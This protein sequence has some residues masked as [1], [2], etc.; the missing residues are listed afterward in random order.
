MT[1]TIRATGLVKCYGRGGAVLDGI[2]LR[3]DAGEFVT[4]MGSSGAGKSTLLYC[5]SGVD[6]P[7]GGCPY[8]VCQAA[9]GSFVAGWGL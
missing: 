9:V 4:I 5:L 2:D 3:V 6:R 7:T 8:V 1:E